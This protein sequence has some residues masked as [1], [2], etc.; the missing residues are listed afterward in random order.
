MDVKTGEILTMA[1][2]PAFDPN[3]LSTHVSSPEKEK[4]KVLSQNKTI[5]KIKI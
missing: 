4:I 3:V 5:Q 1:N 2:S